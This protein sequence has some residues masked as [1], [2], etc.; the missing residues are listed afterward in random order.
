MDA[1]IEL[2]PDR[3]LSTN[4]DDLGIVVRSGVVFVPSKF[5]KYLSTLNVRTGE[6]LYSVLVDLPTAVVAGVDLPPP[7]ALRAVRNAVS[8]LESLV[9]R[10]SVL[11]HPDVQY[12]ARS[13]FEIDP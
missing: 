3:D 7:S 12:G 5:Y 9:G 6:D 1:V 4:P 11:D 2:R 13:P 10:G 8:R